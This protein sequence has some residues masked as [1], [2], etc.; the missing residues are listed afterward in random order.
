MPAIA[1]TLVLRILSLLPQPISFHLPTHLTTKIK[2]SLSPRNAALAAAR[3]SSLK[4]EKNLPPEFSWSSKLAS[5]TTTATTTMTVEGNQNQ[6]HQHQ[7]WRMILPELK[8]ASIIVVVV[9]MLWRF[10]DDRNR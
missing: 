5:T 9:K 8:I 3:R 7:D 1:H 6:N 2:S 10:E 4:R